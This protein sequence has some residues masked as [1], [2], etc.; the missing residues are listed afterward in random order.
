MVNLIG[1]MEE[2][3]KGN[4]I[5]EN[6]MGWANLLIRWGKKEMENGR[7]ESNWVGQAA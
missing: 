3:T 6:S 2:N 4:G 5:M 1:Q 7:M